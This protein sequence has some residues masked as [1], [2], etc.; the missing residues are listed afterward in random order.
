MVVSMVV[1]QSDKDL[2]RQT[3][4]SLKTS[5][6]HAFSTHCLQSARVVVVDNAPGI[7]DSA[8]NN[9]YIEI[10][11]TVFTDAKPHPAI[12]YTL[13][14]SKRNIGYGAANNLAQNDPASRAIQPEYVL[15]LNPDVTLAEDAIRSA[16]VHL[17]RHTAT[18]MVT[19][20]ATFPDGSPQYLVKAHPSV[21]TL[22]CRGFAPA[23]L[24]TRCVRRLAA[25]DRMD[26]AFDAPLFDAEI[27]SGCCMFM[28]ADA[29]HQAGGFDEKFFLYF[30][31]FDLSKRIAAV[32]RIDRVATCRITHAGGNAA[33]KGNR[34][35]WLF[36]RSAARFFN[37]HGWR[38]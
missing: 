28:R 12:T 26:S 10:L 29:W 13:I 5:L 1:Y 36:V 16:V 19:P 17:D 38:W 35:V 37:K 32:S 34:H 11:N 14:L 4:L 20:V 2:F 24:R 7:N 15:V 30:E 3:L 25:Y 27:V 22:A 21:G 23:W 6:Q 33:A 9:E 18:A 8:G 31:D